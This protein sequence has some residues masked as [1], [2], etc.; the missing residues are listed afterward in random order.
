MTTY[1]GEVYLIT[2]TADD[3]DDVALTSADI[4]AMYC[5]VFDSEGAEVVASTEMTWDATREWWYY[6]WVTTTGATPTPIDPG[7]YR[8]RI[9]LVDFED[10]E[11]IEFKR[12]RLA[13]QPAG[14]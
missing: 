12:I 5:E 2:A 3:F 13:R 4:A 10:G 8:A 7:T 11:S 9:V 1:A 14:G 6:R